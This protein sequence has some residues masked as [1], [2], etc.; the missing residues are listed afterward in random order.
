M[1]LCIIYHVINVGRS[2]KNRNQTQNKIRVFAKFSEPFEKQNPQRKHGIRI[3][4]IFLKTLLSILKI[5]C[6][7]IKYLISEI[8]SCHQTNNSSRSEILT[9]E[10]I[11]SNVGDAFGSDTSSTLSQEP[12]GPF[13]PLGERV[14]ARIEG[15]VLRLEIGFGRNFFSRFSFFLSLSALGEFSA[16]WNLCCRGIE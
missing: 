10:S 11:R 7:F 9:T 4:K 5:S 14:G 1:H 12:S 8:K 16:I 3:F 13:S 2:F 6:I 15:L